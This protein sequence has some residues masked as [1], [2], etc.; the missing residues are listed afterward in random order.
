[1]TA[2]VGALLVVLVSSLAWGGLDA[3]RKVLAGRIAPLTLVC[4][5]TLGAVPLF[6]LWV[7]VDGMPAVRP[8]YAV[9]AVCSVLLNVGA[10][11]AYVMAVRTG[12]LSATVPLLS[13][14]PAFT[15]LLAIPLLGERPSLLQGLG[16]LLVVVGA[17]VLNLPVDGEVSVTAALR[18]W[19]QPG[20]LW[21]VAVAFLWALAIPLDKMA[22]ERASGPFHGLVLNAGVALGTLIWLAVQGRVRELGEVRRVRG[23]FAA[24]LAV[25][26]LALGLQLIAIQLVWVSLVETLKRGIGN[27]LAV[28]SGRLLFGEP[29]TGR[30]LAAVALMGAGVALVLLT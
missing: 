22:V 30:K 6:A 18:S 10:N 26:A 24:A 7:A 23:A 1:M 17:V 3:L 2:S 15:A 11:L 21:M 29:I 8:G 14:T 28:I 19:R 20:A 9:P 13:L 5:L 4:L 16:I 25:S 27:V 12:A